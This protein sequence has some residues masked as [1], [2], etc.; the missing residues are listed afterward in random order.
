[1]CSEKNSKR[2]ALRAILLRLGG[3]IDCRIFDRLPKYD[4]TSTN[5]FYIWKCSVPFVVAVLFLREEHQLR[6]HDSDG[7]QKAKHMRRGQ[8]I[9]LQGYE[10]VSSRRR[11][12]R[13][14]AKV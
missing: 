14:G 11:K 9:G 7:G 6:L 3:I 2:P 13:K 12:E 1:M 4:S 5:H 8:V 10:D